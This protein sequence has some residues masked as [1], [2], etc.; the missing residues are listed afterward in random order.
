[1][2]S[3]GAQRAKTRQQIQGELLENVRRAQ[4]DFRHATADNL[5]AARES[6]VRALDALNAF[7]RSIEFSGATGENGNILSR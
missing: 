1:M 6:Y 3:T 5:M 4:A 2:A 7:L